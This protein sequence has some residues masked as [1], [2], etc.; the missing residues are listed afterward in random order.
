[1]KYTP[2]RKKNSELAV[3]CAVLLAAILAMVLLALS[4]KVSYMIEDATGL[5]AHWVWAGL[6]TAA[7]LAGFLAAD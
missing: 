1:M 7:L 3:V 4:L 6:V 5:G 2:I